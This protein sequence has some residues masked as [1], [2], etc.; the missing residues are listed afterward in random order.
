MERFNTSFLFTLCGPDICKPFNLVSFLFSPFS[1]HFTT[2]CCRRIPWRHQQ[3]FELR[4]GTFSI[5]SFFFFYACVIITWRLG[6]RPPLVA[7]NKST[8]LKVLI[9]TFNCL[10]T[11]LVWS[12]RIWT[13]FEWNPTT[14]KRGR[15]PWRRQVM[16]EWQLSIRSVPFDAIDICG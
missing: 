4:R 10:G 6:L 1:F 14:C 16:P 2:D 5:H 15:S 12:R 8:S 3:H 7:R 11:K 9:K 13:S